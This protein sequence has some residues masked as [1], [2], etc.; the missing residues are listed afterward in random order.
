VIV[1]EEANVLINP[2]HPDARQIAAT[3]VRK[4]TY[5]PRLMRSGVGR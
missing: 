2:L 4:W 1:D 3:K 5:D